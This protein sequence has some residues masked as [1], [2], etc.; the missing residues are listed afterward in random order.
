MSFRVGLLWTHVSVEVLSHG[1]LKHF[2]MNR[3]MFQMVMSDLATS[4]D[5]QTWRFWFQN[6]K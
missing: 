4:A 2:E 6:S 3:L 1:R 5:S